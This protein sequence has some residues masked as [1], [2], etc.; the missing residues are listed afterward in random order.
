MSL[1]IDRLQLEIVINNDQARKSLRNLEDEARQL[2]K[3]IKGL[4]EGTKEWVTASDRLKS[5]KVQMDGILEKIGLTGLSMKEL[6]ARQK[7]LNM[8][9]RQMDPRTSQYKE[10]HDQL[11]KVTSRIGELRGKAAEAQLSF[12]GIAD[13]FNRYFAIVTAGAAVFTGMIFSIK[14][15]VTAQGELSDALADIRKTTGL[16]AIEVEALNAALGKI[17]TRTSRQDLRQMAIVAGQLGIAK[18]DILPFVDSVDKLNIALGD[19]IKGGAEEVAKQMGTLRNVLTDMKSGNIADDML[20]IGNA[21]NEL[22]AAGFATAP[23]VVDFA[24]R[25]G[26]VGLSLGLTSDEVLGLSATLQELNVSTERGGTAVTKILQK[27]TTNVADFAK[28]AGIPTK[29]FT[30]LVNTDLFGAFMK[31]LEGSKRGG[32]SA[33]LLSGIIKELEVSGAGASEVFAKLGGN[34]DM[35]SEKVKLAGTS[36]QGT[37][38]IMNEFNIKNNNLAA[39]LA[40][41]QKVFYSMITMPGVTSFFSAQVLNIISLVNWFKE[42]PLFVEKY[43]ITIIALTGVTA[44]WIAAKTRSLQVALLNNLSLKEGMLLKAKDAIVMEYLIVKEQL[45][46]IWKANGTVATKLAATAQMLWNAALAANPI[47]L[48]IAAVTALVGAIAAYE[49][50]SK[51]ALDLD[52]LKGSTTIL[53]ANANKKLLEAYTAIES[54]VNK[55]STLSALEKKDL[56]DK[57]DLTIKLAEAEIVSMEAKQKAIGKESAKPSMWQNL[58]IS[59]IPGSGA[60]GD[61]NRQKAKEYYAWQNQNEAMQPFEQGINDLKASIQKLK[62][63]RQ[64]IVQQLNAENFG[65]QVVGKTFEQLSEKLSK[66]QMALRNTT[67]GSEEYIRIQGKIKEVNK[68]LAKFEQQKADDKQKT[69]YEELNKKIQD[70]MEQLQKVVLT[71]PEQAKVLADKIAKM[72]EYKEAIDE[73]TKSLI[74]QQKGLIS[75]M[76]HINVRGFTPGPLAFQNKKTITDRFGHTSDVPEDPA[77]VPQKVANPAAVE[78]DP[79]TKKAQNFLNYADTVISGL[80]TIDQFISSKENQQL[81]KDTAAT[82]Q[83]KALLQRQ[84]AAKLISQKQYDDGV[85]KLDNELAAKQRKLQHDQA[86]RQKALSLV[87]AIIN[88][89]QGITAAIANPGGPAGMV[90]AIIAGIMGAIQVGFIASTAVPDAAKG[91]YKAIQKTM[92]AAQGKYNVMGQSDG[93]TY[94]D[95]PYQKSFTGIPGKPLLVNETGNEIVID[96]FTT[97]NLLMNY[98]GVIDAIQMARVPQ[99]ASGQ[100]PQAPGGSSLSGIAVLSQEDRQV[101]RDYIEAIKN[102][103]PVKSYTVWSEQQLLNSKMAA[104]ESDVTR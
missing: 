17:D 40:K 42:L 99:R 62:N 4:T 1:K 81:A 83:K 21:V 57:I 25:I 90:L 49:K 66:Y 54:Q 34:T 100:Y 60:E 36:L 103:A 2:N 91:R 97:K 37:D 45:L 88:T 84:L 79:W 72:Q 80:T 10:L 50:Y 6:T 74:A 19:E 48:V 39:S 59:S 98:P 55:L 86:V 9:L 12:K 78:D 11:G 67:A 102:P 41:L 104:I 43:K 71:N 101:M 7:E 31:V 68:D 46:T 96:P 77:N 3:D 38:S 18:N 16:T 28:I 70:Y 94:T 33:T 89:A 75:P 35:L 27:M 13:G 64:N 73:A 5:I 61:A 87:Q 82:E 76:S 93:K 56:Q 20:R 24:N 22:G 14:Q 63:E 23:V 52:R 44:T 8:I 30:D 92:Q 47:G 26:G 15:L 69:A 58:K 51:S 32:Q 65:D 53:L 29:E 95:V 85:A